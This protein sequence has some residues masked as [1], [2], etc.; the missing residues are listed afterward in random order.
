[1]K[2]LLTHNWK[3]CERVHSEKILHIDCTFINLR[4]FYVTVDL[5]NSISTEIK[6]PNKISLSNIQQF[7][8]FHFIGPEYDAY[9]PGVFLFK[10]T[11]ESLS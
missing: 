4:I 8:F 3:T 7:T 2:L 5:F 9:I 1:M 10:K 6:I 11:C